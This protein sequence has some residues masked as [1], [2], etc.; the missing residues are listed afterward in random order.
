MTAHPQ[1]GRG[2]HGSKHPRSRNATTEAAVADFASSKKGMAETEL[3]VC[4]PSNAAPLAR[5]KGVIHPRFA[6]LS[7]GGI[8]G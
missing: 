4:A 2:I 7:V 5:S 6:A 1:K 3:R 8:T